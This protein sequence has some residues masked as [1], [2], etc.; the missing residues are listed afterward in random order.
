MYYVLR[1]TSLYNNHM[2][3]AVKRAR[4]PFD[5]ALFS[6]QIS[7]CNLRDIVPVILLFYTTTVYTQA[8][9]NPSFCQLV[10]DTKQQLELVSAFWYA[11]IL[12][13]VLRVQLLTWCQ[14]IQN[15][16][17]L[18]AYP[19]FNQIAFDYLLQGSSFDLMVTYEWRLEYRIY[20]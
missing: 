8:R 6:I 10:S 5:I 7:T 11:F 12:N 15:I 13:L 17:E 20:A 1:D 2:S 18:I 9:K 16:G 14:T 19:C 4:F 3:G